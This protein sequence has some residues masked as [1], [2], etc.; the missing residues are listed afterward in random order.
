MGWIYR[1]PMSTKTKEEGYT[2]AKL[3]FSDF[4]RGLVSWFPVLFFTSHFGNL[5]FQ[6]K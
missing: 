4:T 5:H 2:E 6:G 3:M 1:P